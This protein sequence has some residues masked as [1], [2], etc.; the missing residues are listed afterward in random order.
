ML[1]CGFTFQLSIWERL[2]ITKRKE[3]LFAGEGKSI[4]PTL[5]TTLITSAD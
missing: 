5:F 3:V 2:P 1:E 4:F